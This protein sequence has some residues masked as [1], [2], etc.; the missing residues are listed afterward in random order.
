MQNLENVA[1][2]LAVGFLSIAPERSARANRAQIIENMSHVV[3]DRV[4]IFAPEAP[5]WSD[6][7]NIFALEALARFVGLLVIA[8]EVSVGR[9]KG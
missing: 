6:G 5:V 2:V 3:A 9:D 1:L 7:F 4:H 8:P